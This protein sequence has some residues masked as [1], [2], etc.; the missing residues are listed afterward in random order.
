MKFTPK[1]DREIQLAMCAD[2]GEYDFEVV[3]AEDGVS[4]SSGNPMTTITLKVFVGQSEKSIKDYLMEKLQ[5]KL[6]HFMYAVGLGAEYE[7]G[8]LDAH[9]LI[10]RSGKLVLGIQQQEGYGPK[11][12]VKDYVVPGKESAAPKA[13]KAAVASSTHDEPPF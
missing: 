2:P 4:K 9:A 8:G 6:K 5:Y 10:G 11:N 12:T 1:T 13:Q 3:G 7:A